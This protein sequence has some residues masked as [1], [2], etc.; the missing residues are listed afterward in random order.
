[1]E[2]MTAPNI[3]KK[4]LTNDEIQSKYDETH[5]VKKKVAKTL[6]L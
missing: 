4:I 3:S 5:K 1:M 2:M 6:M